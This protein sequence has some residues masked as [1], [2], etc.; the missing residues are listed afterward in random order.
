ML[1]WGGHVW[2][3]S[4]PLVYTLQ[5]NAKYAHFGYTKL[6]IYFEEQHEQFYHVFFGTW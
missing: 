6:C 2:A 4:S 5:R 3:A 1:I